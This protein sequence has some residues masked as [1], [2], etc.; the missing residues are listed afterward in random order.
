MDRRGHL[1]LRAAIAA[2]VSAARGLAAS[3]DTVMVTRGS[4]MALH[5]TARALVRPGDVVGVEALGYPHAINVFR[6]A[7]AEVIPIPV[8]RDGLDVTALEALAARRRV[9]LVY[10]TPHH[11]YPT[12]VVL[13]PTRRLALLELA[14][15]HRIAVVEDDYDQEFH[16]DGRPLMPM[17]ASDAGG[18]V[19]Y[20]GT[21][22][23][24]LAPGLRLGF[25]VA[26]PALLS[27]MAAE[28]ALIDGQGDAVLECAVADL[29]EDGEIQ[30]HVR[31]V[32]RIYHQRR[33]A[34]CAALDEGLSRVLTYTR[35][36]GG[37]ALWT[38][39]ARGVDL[40]AWHQRCLE[41]GVFFQLGSQF[42]FDRRAIPFAR[43]GYAALDERSLS[44][45]MRVLGESLV[46]P[47]RA[48]SPRSRRTA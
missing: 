24:I 29:L 3:A 20:V 4:Q 1:R 15:R 37:L 7:R 23:K 34:L 36:A 31:R 32:R 25:V 41:R 28:R 39:V 27:R 14:R 46:R 44:T 12:T 9:R 8:D 13:S 26:A 43:L 19:V 45:A 38:R 6:R 18:N 16:Y 30:R 2:W 33:D 5:L 22:A 47:R 21:L 17:A 48:E 35:P 10:V 40:A 11:Q 42:T